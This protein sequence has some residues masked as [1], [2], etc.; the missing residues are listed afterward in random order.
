MPLCLNICMPTAS[1]SHDDVCRTGGRLGKVLRLGRA[2]RP[3]RLMKRNESM[4]A[5]IDA[6]IGTLRPVAYV[7]LFLLLTMV[8]FGLLG[9][10]LFGGKY[11]H[12]STQDLLYYT[13]DPAVSFP[14]G[15]TEC[16]GAF[17]RDDGTRILTIAHKLC[18]H[19]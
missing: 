19:T 7:I 18:I 15:K 3:L 10:G 9:M 2:L 17:I 13:A 14:F 12:C 16:V 5:V 8:V 4:R 6:L 11:Q 1:T